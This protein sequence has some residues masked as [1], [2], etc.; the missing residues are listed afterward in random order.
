MTAYIAYVT[1][2]DDRPPTPAAL[3]AKYGENAVVQDEEDILSQIKP[4]SEVLVYQPRVG[5][6]GGGY[7]AKTTVRGWAAFEAY[8][9][10]NEGVMYTIQELK[11]AGIG[12][13]P[14]RGHPVVQIGTLPRSTLQGLRRASKAD[15]AAERKELERQRALMEVALRPDQPEFAAQV[16]KNWRDRCPLSGF[17]GVFCEA[18]HIVK[19]TSCD[20]KKAADPDN[21]I[22]LA[23]HLHKAF[24]RYLFSITSDGRNRVVQAAGGGRLEGACSGKDRDPNRRDPSDASL[25]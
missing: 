20:A 5:V 22:L 16:R 1:F 12:A 19:F 7:L 2:P 17:S 18:A 23:A 3:R 25:P 8:R 11:D 14:T 24:D 4:G 21:G 6:V 13:L 10:S 9:E 15:V